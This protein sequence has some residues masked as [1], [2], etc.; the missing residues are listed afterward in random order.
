MK[1]YFVMLVPLELVALIENVPVPR[2]L[3]N[4]I[5]IVF[6]DFVRTPPTHS[7]TKRQDMHEVGP[8]YALGVRVNKTAV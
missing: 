4:A 5:D 3:L 2:I 6:T 7:Y 8:L 1:H